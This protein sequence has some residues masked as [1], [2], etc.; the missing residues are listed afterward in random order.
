M[1]AAERMFREVLESPAMPRIVEKLA[2]ASAAEQAAREHF[3]DT[4]DEGEKHEF[5]NGE[6][7]VH[8]PARHIH[9]KV[10]A[11]IMFVLT[12]HNTA[13]RLGGC[14]VA[15]KSMIELTRNDYEPDVCW[16]SRA[17]ADAIMDDQMLLPPPDLIVEVLSPS[18][19]ARDRGVKKADY[20]AHGIREYWI[21][22]ADARTVEQHI[23]AVGSEEYGA[24]VVGDTLAS[25]A[26]PGLSFRTAILFDEAEFTEAM[27]RG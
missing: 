12:R 10:V 19:A 22:D 26:M 14:I 13:A 27:T 6:H 11:R 17:K 9:N 20:A 23:L 8:S 1:T 16:F 15:E 18:T 21:V 24:P 5:I 7:I 3:R 4:I 2:R 25:A